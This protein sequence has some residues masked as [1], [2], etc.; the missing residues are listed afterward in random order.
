MSKTESDV[1]LEIFCKENECK[2]T[3]C[4]K[5]EKKSSEGTDWVFLNKGGTVPVLEQ[6]TSETN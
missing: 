6:E 1:I 3:L 2:N 5:C 4:M